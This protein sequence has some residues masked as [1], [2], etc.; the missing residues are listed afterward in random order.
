MIYHEDQSDYLCTM[1]VYEISANSQQQWQTLSVLLRNPTDPTSAAVS[2]S[3]KT[4]PKEIFLLSVQSSV[5]SLTDNN[6]DSSTSPVSGSLW[7]SSF[8]FSLSVLMVWSTVLSSVLLSF[9]AVSFDNALS[10]SWSAFCS[11][12]EM[13]VVQ[14]SFS[15]FSG[16]V[17]WLFSVLTAELLPLT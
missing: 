8:D 5:G 6:S 11:F 4:S 10:F 3:D 7:S 12:P 2:G 13:D 14:D 15:T 9:P 1:I 17:V 16:I